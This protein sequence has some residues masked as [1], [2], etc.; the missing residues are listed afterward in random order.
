MSKNEVNE[1]ELQEIKGGSDDS[2]NNIK[3]NSQAFTS[4]CHAAGVTNSGEIHRLYNK[5]LAANGN[6]NMAQ[7]IDWIKQNARTS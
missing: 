3:L 4:L 6:M 5:Y 1:K 7:V 2:G